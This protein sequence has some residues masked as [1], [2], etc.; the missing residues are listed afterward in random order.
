[1]QTPRCSDL[2]KPLADGA[3]SI[4]A[5]L[6][7]VGQRAWVV[8]GAVRDLAL[9][10]PV[11]DVDLVSAATPDV[12]QG[13]FER[14]VPVGAA[15]GIVVVVLGEL[16]FEV[17]TFREERGYSDARRPDEVKYAT[18]P[19]ADALRRDFTCNA[20]YLDPLDDTLCDP[21]GG[22]ADL[23]AGRLA[24]VGEPVARFREDGLRLL[25]MARFEASLGL[26]PAPGLHAAACASLA[27]LGGVSPERVLDELQKV[28]RGPRAGVAAR[29]LDGCGIA[30]LILPGYAELEPLERAL[31]LALLDGHGAPDAVDPLAGERGPDGGLALGLATLLD[32]T[33][34][35]LEARLEPLR[36]SRATLR[37]ALD[38]AEL[39]RRMPEL[40]HLETSPSARL[41]AMRSEWFDAA[42]GLALRRARA[43][44]PEVEPAAGPEAAPSNVATLA[45]LRG[46]VSW[47][48]AA[49]DPS[50]APWLRASDLA[51][52]GL[53]PGP[54]FGA[55]LREAETLQ[56]DGVLDDRAAALEWLRGQVARADP[57][58]REPGTS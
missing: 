26:A 18:S 34:G 41:R 50:P 33:Q 19:E 47:T 2:P 8:G 23:A 31:R 6:A 49:G 17:A 42:L 13:L 10:R 12:V 25:R 16:E 3:R 57:R 45:A 32:D 38:V 52:S 5:R 1:M 36:P 46:L 48:R 20:L 15:F 43:A 22:L 54:R 55:L 29:V 7:E 51:A 39:A 11:H 9:A 14:T 30:A 21:A 4:A 58:E 40:A 24:T 53:A 37:G 44:R 35:R 28:L 27:A 56:L